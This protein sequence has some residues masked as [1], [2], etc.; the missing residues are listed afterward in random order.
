MAI[1][2]SFSSE[3]VGRHPHLPP[4]NNHHKKPVRNKKPIHDH[5]KPKEQINKKEKKLLVSKI[6]CTWAAHNKFYLFNKQNH[7]PVAA[8]IQSHKAWVWSP[9][10][11]LYIHWQ[12][13]APVP[14]FPATYSSNSRSM[15][16]LPLNN[17]NRQTLVK[18]KPVCQI[19]FPTKQ[20]LDS[21]H[22]IVKKDKAK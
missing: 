1:P 13:Q 8:S 9:R 5:S 16:A 4:K 12:C 6:I 11:Q 2:S 7:F 17:C 3:S 22:G 19:I 18:N 21:T 14:P 15:P 10:A 20:F